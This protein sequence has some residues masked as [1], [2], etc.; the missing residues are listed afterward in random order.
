MAL[1]QRGPFQNVH[2]RVAAHISV[3]QQQPGFGVLQSHVWPTI[4][5]IYTLSSEAS[6]KP[7]EHS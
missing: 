1:L 2:C 7:A 3:L 4:N 5:Y 6:T